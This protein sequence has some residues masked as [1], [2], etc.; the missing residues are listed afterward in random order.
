MAVRAT[1]AL[2]GAAGTLSKGS[3][4]LRRCQ[5][6]QFAPVGPTDCTSRTRLMLIQ[7]QSVVVWHCRHYRDKSQHTGQRPAATH[8]ERPDALRA[9]ASTPR[10]EDS[11]S[12]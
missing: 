8:A 9:Q 2:T 1:A 7:P 3:N 12:T 4:R 11:G 6:A 5:G 10:A